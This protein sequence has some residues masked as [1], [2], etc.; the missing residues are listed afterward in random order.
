VEAAGCSGSPNHV[1]PDAQRILDV[2]NLL[3][4]VRVKSGMS[5][6]L[7]RLAILLLESV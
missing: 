7:L 1:E 4:G 5:V 3:A 6:P 2:G